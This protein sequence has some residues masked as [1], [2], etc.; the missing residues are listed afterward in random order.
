MR[1]YGKMSAPCSGRNLTERTGA[2]AGVLGERQ[3]GNSGVA[4]LPL[5]FA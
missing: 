4:A 1:G 2:L 5:L 3:T